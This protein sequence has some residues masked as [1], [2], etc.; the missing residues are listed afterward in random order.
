MF[1]SSYQGY[2]AWVEKVLCFPQTVNHPNKYN[3]YIRQIQKPK[4][5]QILLQ[6]ILEKVRKV[7]LSLPQ[8]SQVTALR[9]ISSEGTF[10]GQL[11]VKV[12]MM[13]KEKKLS[14]HQLS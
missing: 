14:D 6:K 7:G 11:P 4:E 12:E 9:A 8:T 1:F 5:I 3:Y 10:Y 13:Q 2:L